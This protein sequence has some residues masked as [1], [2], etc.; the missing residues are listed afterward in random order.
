MLSDP[1]ADREKDPIIFVI[2]K[3]AT[4]FVPPFPAI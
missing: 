2:Q 1:R 3:S 4:T